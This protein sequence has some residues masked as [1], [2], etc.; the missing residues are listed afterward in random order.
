MSS[1]TLRVGLIGAGGIGRTHLASYDRVREAQIVAIADIHE[2][3]ARTAAQQVG[4]QAF[5]D[6]E[7]MLHRVELDAVDICTPPSAHLEVALLAIEHGLHVICEKPLAHHPDAARQMVR[8]AEEKGIKLMT[9]FCHRF[10]PPI[11]ALKR[12]IEAGD[13][14]EV[15]MFRNRFAGPFKGVEERWFSDKEVAGGG[16]LMDTSVHSIDLFRFLVGE[17]ARVQAVVRQTSPAI[18]KVE[19]TAIALLSTADNRMGVVEASWVL[20]AGFNVVE[21][22]GTEGAAMVHYW[23]GFK[24]RYK[25][26]KMDDWQPIEEVGPDRFVGEIQHFVDACLGRTELQVTGYDGLRAVEIVYQAYEASVG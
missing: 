14:G 7:Q 10:H 17:V 23:D 19:D 16:V 18:G 25:T 3:T 1:Y 13:L 21:I 26:S 12:L 24:S 2:E 9:A 5:R 15:V 8:A 6:V 4:A 22:Y 20:A 11:R